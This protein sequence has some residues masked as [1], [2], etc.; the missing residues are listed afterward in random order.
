MDLGLGG[1]T[2]VVT[3]GTKGMG[4]AV[5]LTLA[6]E[7]AKVAVMARGQEALDATVIALKEAGAPDA[8]G[9]VTDFASAAIRAG[10]PLLREAEWARMAT[11]GAQS[12]KLPKA[13]TIAYSA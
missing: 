9:I 8:L 12:V 2:A 4:R 7:G 6:Q 1:A 3:G 11:F 13:R 5:A 10:L